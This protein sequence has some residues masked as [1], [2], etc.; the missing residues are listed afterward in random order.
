MKE[1][2]N[3]FFLKVKN[4]DREKRK[5]I[6]MAICLVAGLII[7][8]FFTP[9][10]DV[11]NIIVEGNDSVSEKT[12]A[13]ASGIIYGESIFK[14]SIP[15]VKKRLSKVAFVDSA[16]VR[17]VLPDRIKI[18]VK[19]REESAYISFIGNYIGIDDTGKILEVKQKAEDVSKPIVYGLS[20]E[21]FEIGST[22]YTENEKG[23][24]ILYN[25]LQQISINDIGDR[26]KFIDVNDDD[27]IRLTLSNNIEVKLG[28]MD[29]IK[30]KMAYLK[31]VIEEIK[32]LNGGILDITDTENVTYRAK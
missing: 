7:V 18:V 15:E 29:N 9:V 22:I 25:I 10:Y 14:V 23:R 12:I 27:N 13:D 6:L 21:N 26:I 28:N 11:E 8:S 32:D 3:S 19:E 5:S 1:K 2:I 17:Y 31:S 20:I 4:L 16:R 24:N 30:Y